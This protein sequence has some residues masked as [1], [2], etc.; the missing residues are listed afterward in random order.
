MEA[1]EEIARQLRLRDIG[2]LVVMDFIDLDKEAHRKELERTLRELMKKDRARTRVAG[3]S[4]FGVIEMTRQR[5][6][7]SLARI[8]YDPCPTCG[9]EGVVKSMESL[10]LNLIRGLRRVLAQGGDGDQPVEVR[11]SSAVAGYLLNH[12]RRELL[13]IED[14]FERKIHVYVDSGLRMDEIHVEH[15]KATRR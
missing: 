7:P 1:A 4:P 15:R 6:G 5:V 14:E 11:V 9:G 2:G 10:G 3:I 13:S 8:S 12:K